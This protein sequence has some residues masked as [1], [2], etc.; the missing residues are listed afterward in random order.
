MTSGEM[1][2]RIAYRLDDMVTRVPSDDV[3]LYKAIQNA[4]LT[5]FGAMARDVPLTE[6]AAAAF[7]E[8]DA[9]VR[10]VEPALL[11]DWFDLLP[12]SVKYLVP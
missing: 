11:F 12:S 10:D 4:W 2:D 1:L 5:S 7:E 6:K 8:L 3:E 9:Y